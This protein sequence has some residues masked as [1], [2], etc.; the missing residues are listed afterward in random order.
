MTEVRDNPGA[1]GWVGGGGGGPV[2]VKYC[3]PYVITVVTDST[4]CNMGAVWHGC[5][6]SE[7]CS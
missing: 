7:S 3:Q 4:L 1:E 6:I 2:T 5:R